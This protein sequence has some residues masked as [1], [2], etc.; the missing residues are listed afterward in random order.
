MGSEPG[1]MSVSEMNDTENQ[2]IQETESASSAV[3]SDALFAARQPC[4]DYDGDCD[5]M[6]FEQVSACK[7]HP[8]DCGFC[9]MEQ[10]WN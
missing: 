3:A 1:I 8:D 5:D 10:R 7:R 9:V 4:G 6:T 2:R